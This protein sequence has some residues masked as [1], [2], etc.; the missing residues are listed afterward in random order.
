MSN[1]ARTIGFEVPAA[2]FRPVLKGR[3][4]AFSKSS[5]AD[6]ETVSAIC[7]LQAEG[8]LDHP[9]RRVAATRPDFLTRIWLLKKTRDGEAHG[10]DRPRAP[11]GAPLESDAFM[12][13][14]VRTLLPSIRFEGSPVGSPSPSQAD[15]RLDARTSLLTTFGHPTFSK[16]GPSARKEHCEEPRSSGLCTK[17]A[18]MHGK[19]SSVSTRRFKGS[20]SGI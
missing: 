20:F 14:V 19:S 10:R 8:Q 4:I 13:E 5:E 3:L 7:L 18:T 16:L 6:M 2:G 12:Q 9:L 15:R 1:I 17:M 11:G